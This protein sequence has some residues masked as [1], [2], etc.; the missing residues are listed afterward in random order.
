L[1]AEAHGQDFDARIERVQALVERLERLDDPVARE[2]A[3]ELLQTV[4]EL[5]GRAFAR[6]L[7]LFG[8]EAA[9]ARAAAADP[10]LG[11]VL[12]L[13]DLGPAPA[14]RHRPEPDAPLVPLRLG[15]DRPAAELAAGAC[16]LC[17]AVIPADPHHEHLLE[18]ETGRLLCGC[19]AC[20]LLFDSA[21]ETRFWR[22]PR[23]VRRVPELRFEPADWEALGIPI[24][25]A[26]FVR[27]AP[28]ETG[29]AKAV[30]P[31]PAGPVTSSLSTEQ[32]ALL[33]ERHGAF[34]ALQPGV[35]A[36]LVAELATCAGAFRLPIDACFRLV[37]LV[38]QKWRGLAGGAEL[39]SELAEFV[40]ALSR[41]AEEALHA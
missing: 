16:G 13:H 28:N 38:R 32:L 36:L 9:L 15:R 24:R 18:V 23:G 11:G 3:R 31:S 1:K 10:A 4:L 6:L 25:L 33:E 34:G 20:A 2:T 35:E 26:F 41:K 22:L 29:A 17:G 39:E 8:D 21:G 19:L 30:F 12:A 14:A 37:G 27:G 5:H 40:Q 7:E